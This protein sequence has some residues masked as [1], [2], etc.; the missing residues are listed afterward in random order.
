MFEGRAVRQLG[1][2]VKE[3]REAARQHVAL[4]GS[5][6]FI[7]MPRLVLPVRHRG[8]E[9]ELDLT[10]AFGQ[11]GA[12]QVELIQQNNKGPSPFHDVYPEGSGTYGF[13]HVAYF[14]DDVAA[15]REQCVKAGHPE[16]TKIYMPDGSD[17]FYADARPTFGH[18]L[19]VYGRVPLI[20][21]SYDYVAKIAKGWDGKNPV[22]DVAW[23]DI[24]P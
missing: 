10:L 15:A 11:W 1:Y 2:F 21:A 5:G 4:Y 20:V 13:H 23:E 18:Y 12:M 9:M 19:E 17:A 6:P 16:A 22:R 24:R 7:V 14:V 8:Q 3:V